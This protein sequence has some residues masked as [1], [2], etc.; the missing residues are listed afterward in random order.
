MR[1]SRGEGGYSFVACLSHSTIDHAPQSRRSIVSNIWLLS[2]FLPYIT[3]IILLILSRSS[4]AICGH[5]LS[6]RI[7]I[8]FSLS[9]ALNFSISNLSIFLISSSNT[10]RSSLYSSH[11]ST[12]W[13]LLSPALPQGQHLRA[14]FLLHSTTGIPYT[15]YL[16]LL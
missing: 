3:H 12:G 16:F 11:S 10:F 5:Y 8:V 13:V 14:F 1:Y 4:S 6:P 9:N 2:T 7:A 15:L